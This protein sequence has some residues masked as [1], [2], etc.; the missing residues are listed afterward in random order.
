MIRFSRLEGNEDVPHT[1][2]DAFE[3]QQTTG[4][5]RI[6]VA[7]SSN[8]FSLLF[9]LA[10]HLP[11]PFC[12]L[13]I[14]AVSRGQAAPGRYQSPWLPLGELQSALEPHHT[15]ISEDGRS[16]LWL[17][18]H[19]ASATLVWDN[20]NVLYLYGPLEHFQTVLIRAGLSDGQI[21]IPFPHS[22]H[23]HAALD[24]HEAALAHL[25]PWRVTPLQESD[26]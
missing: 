19:A 24:D 18:C 2:N 23:Y 20:H 25:F 16:H 21:S 22:H 4:R 17:F 13:W 3:R 26:E 1:Y 5:E 9:H 10:Q 7:P 12:A 6:A 11:D 8:H 14:L 15:F